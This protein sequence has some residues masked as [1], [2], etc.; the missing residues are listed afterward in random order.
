M[1]VTRE[2][3]LLA[4]VRARDEQ[5]TTRENEL[6]AQR[7]ELSQ[8]TDELK[9][10]RVENELLKQK[11]D[12]LARQLFGKKS[13]QL[14]ANQL[15]LLF[16]ELL[17]PGPAAGKELGPEATQALPPRPEST[18]PRVPRERAQRLPEHLPV[19]EEV[20]IPLPVQAAPEQFRKIGEEV[21]ERLDYTPAKFVRLR[22][23]RPKYVRRQDEETK[24]IIAPLP[25]CILERSILTPGLLAQV[26][27]AKYCDHLPL[28]RQECI[29][30]TRHGVT[31]S[32]QSLA[33]WTGVGA[34]W[35][36]PIYQAIL[37]GVM[38][39]GYVQ[40]DETP[41][42]Y[43]APGHGKTKQGYL[44]TCHRPGAGTAYC[45]HTT[46]AASCLED[47]VPVD[48]AGRI[49]CDGYSGYDAFAATRKLIEL[50]G[51]WAHV[52]RGFYEAATAQQC[53]EALLILYLLQRL[54][55]TEKKLRQARAGPKIRALTRSLESRPIVGKIHFLLE[56]WQKKRRFLPQSLMGKAISYALG[57]WSS[58]LP[59][60][61]DGR[62]EIDNNQ[63]E[64]AI[65]PTALG[66]K[67]WLFFGAAE[68]GH[69]GAIIY[70]IIEC[71]RRL[72][73][74]PFE[75]LRDI[76]S[77]LPNATNW[78]IKDLTPMAWAEARAKAKR[79][80]AKRQRAA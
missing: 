16:Q 40:V 10:L 12:K 9:R 54:Y 29:Y 21:T 26:I 32:R 37:A 78:Q 2:T 64:N 33:Q 56:L 4:Q 76:F 70:T 55:R 6:L 15:Q 73:I 19:V 79:E 62:L 48:F 8:L 75:Y 18:A 47:I 43:L 49:Q 63:V 50:I 14:D 52:R 41:I 5:L 25:G 57:Q 39:A 7:A 44:W 72:D 42:R 34:D 22:T 60:L 17:T 13:E 27:V 1:S 31:I 59:Y 58:L 65:R 20:L 38:S 61:S 46:R 30:R 24:P 66:K 23:V 71:C 74:D 69:R 11:L 67:N 68:A 77:R 35:L 51:C 3:E 28:Y 80:Q 36:Q 53:K 45:W